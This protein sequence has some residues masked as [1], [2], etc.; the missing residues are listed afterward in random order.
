M[1]K[2]MKSEVSA[3]IKA[4][5]VIKE[6]QAM[7]PRII[8]EDAQGLKIVLQYHTGK[9]IEL[10]TDGILLASNDPNIKVG[11]GAVPTIKRQPE[12]SPL[13]FALGKNAPCKCKRG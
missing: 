4:L 13:E 6:M 3:K 2:T 8:I 12:M 9:S 5:K 10:D 7:K 11:F 1:K